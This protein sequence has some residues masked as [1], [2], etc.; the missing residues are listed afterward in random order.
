MVIF[1]Y[2]IELYS[3]SVPLESQMWHCLSRLAFPVVRF[4]SSNY[5]PEPICIMPCTLLSLA[6]PVRQSPI[7][8]LFYVLLTVPPNIMIVFFFTNMMH[9]FFVLIHLL[10]SST[11]FEHYCAHLQEDI[12]TNTASGIV[13]LFG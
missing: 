2:T 7:I 6:F 10:H 8:L 9:K 4:R 3:N 11:C 13:T 1:I 5:L 12:Y